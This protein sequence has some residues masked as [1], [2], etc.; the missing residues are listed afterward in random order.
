VAIVS[1]RSLAKVRAFVGLEELYYA[2]SHG[3]DI[4]GPG[5]ENAIQHHQVAQTYLPDLRTAAERIGEEVLRKYVGATI[6]DNWLAFSVHYRQCVGDRAEVAVGI[7][8]I[9]DGVLAE[10]PTLKKTYGKCVFELRP[11]IDWDKGKA[12]S[13][14]LTAL[15]VNEASQ[16]LP[17]Y[18]GDD[19]TD[20]DA[21]REL[22]GIGLSA[23]V[24]DKAEETG[25]TCADFVLRDPFE[26]RDFLQ[27]FV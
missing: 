18:I 22:K 15:K 14:L 6:E 16:F 7:E 26:V 10:F 4:V 23:I 9:V 5:G 12:V 2:G 11:K 27:S 3:F 13:W 20:E 24:R 1:G 17:I 8:K 19:K 25:L 21:F